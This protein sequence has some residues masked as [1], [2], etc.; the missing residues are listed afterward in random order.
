MVDDS[1]GSARVYKLKTGSKIAIHYHPQ[2]TYGL[3]MLSDLFATI[4]WTEQ[5]LKRLKLIH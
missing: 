4:G 1:H 3:R 2:K 5:D